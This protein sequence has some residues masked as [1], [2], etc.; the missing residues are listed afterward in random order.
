MSWGAAL[1]SCCLEEQAHSFRFMKD[2]SAARKNSKTE[3]RSAL[4]TGGAGYVGSRLVYR[5]LQDGWRVGVIVRPTSSLHLLATY[6]NDLEIYTHDGSAGQM[7]A[8]VRKS[9]P[10]A[11]F[12]LAAKT[13]ADHRPEDVEELVGSNVTFSTQLLEAMRCNKSRH[14]INTETFWQYDHMTGGYDPVCLYAATKQACRDILAYY[15]KVRALDAVSLVLYDTYGPGDPRKKLFNLLKQAI[16]TG[17]PVDMTP[18]E[19]LVDMVHVDDV[20]D[21]Y[22]QAASMLMTGVSE[23][24]QTYA[25]S[26]GRRIALKALVDLIRQTTGKSIDINWGAKPYR[27]NEVMVPWHGSPPPGWRPRVSL[28]AGILQLFAET[29]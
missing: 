13:A 3:A 9:N 20:V 23:N 8:I 25:V 24:L 16:R 1:P 5:L 21:A 4:V 7:A 22:I 29:T 14:I 15:T 10:A 19:Q 28:E 11:V 12:H 6:L 26:S 18:G 17:S 27:E 2:S